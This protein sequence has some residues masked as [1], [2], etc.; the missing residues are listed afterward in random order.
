MLLRPIGKQS[1]L[2]VS[3]TANPNCIGLLA[4]YELTTAKA[5]LENAKSEKNTWAEIP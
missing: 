3:S 4:V 1:E 2:G 5:L